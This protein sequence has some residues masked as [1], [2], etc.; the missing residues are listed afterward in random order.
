MG[1]LPQILNIKDSH[2][3]IQ[4]TERWDNV[5]DKW[6]QAILEKKEVIVMADDNM[7]FD[8][9]NYNNRYRIKAIKEKTIQF[10]TE[11]NITIHNKEPTYFVNQTPTS[12]IDHIYSN[13]PQKI[14]HIKTINNG[15][16]DHATITATYHTKAP[17][18]NPKVIYTR[19]KH[20]LTEHNL[21]KYLNNNDI[22]QTVYNYTDPELIAEILMREYNNIIEIIAPRTKRQV[23]K[24]YTPY[25][26]KETREGKRKLHQMH[27]KAKQ[28][29]DNDHWREYKNYRATL[30][31]KI[32]KQK[33]DYIKKKLDNSEDRWKT[34]NNINNKKTFTSPRSIIH[35]E[36]IITNIKEI[37]NLAN[38][39][40]ISLIRKL[41]E[42]IPK[43]SVTP[44]DIIKKI[45]PRSKVTLEI[46]IPT[47]KAITDIIK[48]AK[49][50]NSVGHDNISMKMLK[51]TTKTM[52]PLIT[53]LVKQ[54][55]LEHKFLDVFKIDRITPKLKNGKPIYDIGSY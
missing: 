47:N 16:S 17:I 43:I 9:E 23:K 2:G 12:C 22:I 24:N 33:Q 50:K 3:L 5:L 13:C 21:N 51:K 54:I 41:R 19:P 37:C 49:S 42:N 26:D 40:Y 4:Q 11:H 39:Y 6:Q 8:N 20:L 55:I 48:K 14:T 46:P 29:Q 32:D 10:L 34:L 18:N 36:T 30:N 45:Y 28:T 25:L 38:N 52:A 53:H 1:S 35:K 7:D 44:I 31:K 15:L 27:N